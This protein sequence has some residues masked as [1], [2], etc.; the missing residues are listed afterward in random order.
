VEVLLDFGSG[1]NLADALTRRLEA[2]HSEAPARGGH[3]HA[4]QGTPSIHDIEAGLRPDERPPVD[5]H[6]RALFVE[7]L[8]SEPLAEQ[9]LRAGTQP[10]LRS[11]SRARCR[12]EVSHAGAEVVAQLTA[13][14]GWQKTLSLAADG[15]VAVGY[16]WD[17][18][19]APNGWFVTELSMGHPATLRPDPDAVPIVYPIETVAKS[20]RGFDRTRQ[21]ECRTFAWPASLGRASIRLTPTSP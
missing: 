13:Q 6:N 10:M 14:D 21:G 4:G 5:P 9:S 1:L 8:A 7:W 2:Y 17:R 18:A 16:R 15:S 11:W 19:W 3:E 20:E 12:F